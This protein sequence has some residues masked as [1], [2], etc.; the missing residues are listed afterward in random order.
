MDKRTLLAFAL[1]MLVYL[2]WMAWFAPKPRPGAED[3]KEAA[4]PAE[5]GAGDAF[6]EMQHSQ[7]EGQTG[8]D[9]KAQATT[10]PAKPTRSA[11]WLSA[12]PTEDGESIRVET[13]LFIATFD[14]VGADL[15]SF[16]L[17]QFRNLDQQLVELIP[18][19]S[20]T[21]GV[22]RAHGLALVFEDGRREALS[23]VQFET[24]HEELLLDSTKPSGEL[25][26]AAQNG[27][28]GSSSELELVLRF[29]NDRYGFDAELSYTADDLLSS[30]VAVVLDWSAGIA[31]SEPDTLQEYH[32]FRALAGVGEE[33]H[34]KKFDSLRKNGGAGGRANYEG[35][36]R[37]AGVSSRYFASVVLA[38][39]DANAPGY[40]RL[41]GDYGRH[42]QTFTVQLP[43]QH[44]ARSMLK[45]GVYLGPL[46]M[47]SLR[48]FAA[49][50]YN[51]NVS[52][53]VDLGPKI[54][55]FAAVATVWCLKAL[56]KVIPNYGWVIIIFSTLTKVLFYPLTK[57][58]TQSMKR[59]QEIQPKLTKLKEKYKDD[60]AKQSREMMALY[61]EHKINPMGGCLPLVVQMP[62]FIAL[63]Q[64][65][66]KTIELRQ[67]PFFGWIHDLSRPDV[68][69]ELPVTLPVLGSHF[70][71]LPLLM[72][73]GMW[74]Q[75]K[76]TPQAVPQGEGVMAM[77][78]KMM[79]TVMPF[80]MFF[81]FYNSPS[82]L[83]LYWLLNTVLTAA[84]TWHI[85]RKSQP[86]NLEV[87]P[88]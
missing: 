7:T 26:L 66:R 35:T 58:S 27:E 47:D 36:I 60:Q 80:M 46:D 32:E 24:T 23:N 74:L 83:V 39:S 79:G 5:S 41:D 31:N 42:L 70:S 21:G 77:N 63:Y 37:L 73:I 49:E 69:F 53:L 4:L 50:P 72:A 38:T 84:Q 56:Y 61:K 30:P 48:P 8:A 65:L 22:E 43:T 57:S 11:G 59:M 29:E 86:L 85:Q 28:G 6:R 12:A 25:R 34:K 18:E 55:R 3:A 13:D 54:F 17:K 20:L 51:A 9:E 67:A 45:Y 78:A 82:G 75:T 76:F 52:A 15:R 16:R 87:S 62:V 40:V 71:L 44:A 14:R 88:A 68:L 81:L 33:L 10:K 19:H 64:V 2:G 1:M